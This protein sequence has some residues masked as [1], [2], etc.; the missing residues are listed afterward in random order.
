MK[1]TRFMMILV[2]VFSIT[3][4][5][6]ESSVVIY[7]REILYPEGFTFPL[8]SMPEKLSLIECLRE[9]ATL[10]MLVTIGL[11]AGKTFSQRFA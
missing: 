7:L 4:A 8:N 6:M 3:M 9:V 10:I 5:F 11:V 1:K 2:T